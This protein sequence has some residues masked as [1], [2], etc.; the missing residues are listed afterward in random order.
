MFGLTHDPRYL[1]QPVAAPQA[2]AHQRQQA[3]QH[4]HCNTITQPAQHAP[5]PQLAQRFMDRGAQTVQKAIAFDTQGE[6][7]EAVAMYD[8]AILLYMEGLSYVGDENTKAVVHEGIRPYRERS[9][10]LH[11]V[12]NVLPPAT[13]VVCH[14]DAHRKAETT[15]PVHESIPATDSAQESSTGTLSPAE[16]RSLGIDDACVHEAGCQEEEP[17]DYHGALPVADQQQIYDEA[18]RAEEDLRRET[19]VVKALTRES[20]SLTRAVTQHMNAYLADDDSG[21]SEPDLDEELANLDV[22]SDNV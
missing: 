16:L 2:A 21:G 15:P 17:P 22:G 18:K 5:D 1:Q 7:N 14:E 20:E 6:L 3:P 19:A 10:V 9:E 8:T 4:L 12:L 11:C 13:V